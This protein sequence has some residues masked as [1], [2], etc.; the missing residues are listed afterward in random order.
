NV[1]VDIEYMSDRVER[2]VKRFIRPDEPMNGQRQHLINWSAK[3]TMYKYFSEE[4]L[5]YFDMRVH[6]FD[7][8]DEGTLIIDDLKDPKSLEVRY[9][10]TDEYVITYSAF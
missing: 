5:Q 6:A 3:E 8:N 9:K 10:V 1:A 2:I 4:D 7:D